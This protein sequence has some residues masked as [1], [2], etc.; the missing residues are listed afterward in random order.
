MT[1]SLGSRLS[2]ASAKSAASSGLRVAIPRH[3][4][5]ADSNSAFDRAPARTR[6]TSSDVT[7]LIED[8]WGAHHRPRFASEP[9]ASGAP[10]LSMHLPA[11]GA[12]SPLVLLAR[13]AYGS[14]QRR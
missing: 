2:N 6:S 10:S 1:V 9:C 7:G 13:A 14:A 11:R 3:V 8:L 5:Y 12:T 4:R